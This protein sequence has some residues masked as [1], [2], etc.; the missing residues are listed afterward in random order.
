MKTVKLK[1]NSVSE[2]VYDIGNSRL[3]VYKT[4]HLF[5]ALSNVMKM[6]RKKLLKVTML[7]QIIM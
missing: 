2:F 4:I 6:T 7:H 3:V 5:H 1:A